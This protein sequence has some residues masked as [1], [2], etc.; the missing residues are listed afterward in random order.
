MTRSVSDSCWDLTRIGPE[1]ADVALFNP[2]CA[3]GTHLMHPDAVPILPRTAA[4]SPATVRP[5][6]LERWSRI[7][8]VLI[9]SHM[10]VPHKTHDRQGH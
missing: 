2:Q 5:T 3:C 1:S 8:C 4:E 10:S 6:A 7:W 9:P